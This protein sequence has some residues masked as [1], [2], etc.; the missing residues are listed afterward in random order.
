MTAETEHLAWLEA[1]KGYVTASDVAAVMGIDPHKKRE[2]VLRQKAGL[3]AYP[4]IDRVPAVAAGRHLEAGILAW[5]A[6]DHAETYG[7]VEQNGKVLALSSSLPCL[8]ATPDGFAYGGDVVDLVEVKC[9]EKSWESG[10]RSARAPV[11][12]R[13]VGR[14]AA[15]DAAP[16]KYWVQLQC[17]LHCTQLSHGWLTALQGAHSRADR[18]YAID[19]AFVARMLT[20]VERFWKEVQAIRRFDTE[21]GS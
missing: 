12:C 14:A 10:A 11:L 18:L 13:N 5:F 6:E 2:K 8:A 20:E 16:M 4:N 3:E 21:D 15:G 1:R 9:V 19:D 17:Q 7:R